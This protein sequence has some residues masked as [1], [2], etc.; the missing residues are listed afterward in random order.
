MIKKRII[1][2]LTLM[3][4]FFS[5]TLM[6]QAED[7]AFKP[8]KKYSSKQIAFTPHTAFGGTQ[9][10]GV[11]TKKGRT[12]SISDGNTIYSFNMITEDANPWLK[13][14]KLNLVKIGSFSHKNNRFDMPAITYLF[15][16]AKDDATQRAVENS[17]ITHAI[18]QQEQVSDGDQATYSP[19]KFKPS[20]QFSGKK[21]VGSYLS[22]NHVATI[23][24][25]AGI[26]TQV[27]IFENVVEGLP[28]SMT[29]ETVRP[30]NQPVLIGS[31]TSTPQ[32]SK[33]IPQICSN[34]IR[35]TELY[36]NIKAQQ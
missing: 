7:N 25:P 36:G 26:N 9:A 33:G 34:A 27:Y 15:G 19:I 32:C 12:A 5:Y 28:I 6:L 3:A 14:N 18:L 30:I 13:N 16:G 20:K 22:S 10:Q 1:T 35:V 31:Y 11:Y 24:D 4:T 21:L 8:N 2:T 29:S 17:K 23:Q